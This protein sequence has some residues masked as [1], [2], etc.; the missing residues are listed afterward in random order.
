VRGDFHA[1]FCERLALKCAGL[2]D[3]RIGDSLRTMSNDELFRILSERA[4][5]FSANICE[6]LT[7]EDL[8][9][10]A[11]ALM[12]AESALNNK[13]LYNIIVQPMLIFEEELLLHV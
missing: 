2:L 4:P 3:K 6:R 10:E 11:I 13:D 1:R 7:F 9:P 5:D 8:D 12:K